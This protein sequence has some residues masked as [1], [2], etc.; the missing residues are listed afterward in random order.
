MRIAT[1][2]LR[3]G[4]SRRVHWLR[5]VEGHGVDLLL[6]QESYAPDEH[7]PPPLHPDARRRAAWE[8]AGSNG[9]GSAVFSA[10]GSV[11]PVAVEGFAGWVVGADVRGAPWQ[12][13][14]ADPLRAFSVHAPSG[15]GRYVGQVNRIL[16]EI[17]KLARGRAVVIGG[18]FN[19]IVSDGPGCERPPSRRE[20]AIQERLA[21]E[22]GL[23]N[24]WQ[25]A[26]PGRAPPQTLRWAGAP[27]TAYHCDG[28]FVPRAWADRLE[29]CVVLAG[30]E[31]NDLSDHNPVVTQFR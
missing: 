7:L 8:A 16:D 18:D 23:A 29:S 4:G 15:E 6:A 25:A 14:F 27:A 26:N 11:T 9:W 13:G 5:M 17:K 1:Y 3:K 22:F 2:N 12:A 24:G 19:V 28:L 31:W 30:G 10:G 21:E 20:R